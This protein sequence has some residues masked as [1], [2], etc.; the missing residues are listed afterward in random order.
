MPTLSKLKEQ[1]ERLCPYPIEPW[2]DAKF[3]M[4]S[5]SADSAFA[6]CKGHKAVVSVIVRPPE[7][8]PHIVLLEGGRTI[9]LQDNGGGQLEQLELL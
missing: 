7:G 9:P 1:A 5:L 4:F 6:D 8:A 3:D 2:R